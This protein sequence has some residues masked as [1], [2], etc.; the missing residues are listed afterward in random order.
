MKVRKLFA[1]TFALI[2]ATMLLCACEDAYATDTIAYVAGTVPEG[3]LETLTSLE[4][5]D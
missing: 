4:D 5:C 3:Y 2:L 1:T